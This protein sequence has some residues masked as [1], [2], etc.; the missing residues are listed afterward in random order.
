MAFAMISDLLSLGGIKSKIMT[1]NGHGSTET[2]S[3][4]LRRVPV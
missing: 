3:A 2:I 4:T 1:G